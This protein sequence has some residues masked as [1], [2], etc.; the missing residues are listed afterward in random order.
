LWHSLLGLLLVTTGAVATPVYD[1]GLV[2]DPHSL[3]DP[4][5]VPLAVTHPPPREPTEAEVEQYRKEAEEAAENKNWL[6]RGFEQQQQL[7]NTGS[8]D[9]ST[10]L[11]LQLSSNKALAKLAGLPETDTTGTALKTGA[12]PGANGPALRNDTTPTAA[13][14]MP[15]LSDLSKPLVSPLSLPAGVTTFS[16]PPPLATTAPFGGI[17]PQSTPSSTPA[18]QAEES[19]DLD[20]PG[21][22]A[23][24]KDPSEDMSSA[25]LTL[26]ILPGESVEEARARQ[27]NFKAELALP[28]DADQLHK[29]Q[30][31]EITVPAV[32]KIA[33][34]D[35]T[36]QSTTPPKTK[37]EDDPSAPIPISQVPQINPVRAPIP[38]PFDILNR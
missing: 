36:A 26:D 1:S 35:K 14:G 30:T 9:Q 20:T 6:L 3:L 37:P 29:Q 24:K 33:T 13:T 12:A 34:D 4:D 28:M 25:D 22:T 5:G 17:L 10:D 18:R 16:A 8:P 31:S 38:G 15:Y 2:D 21:M 7:H 32:A 19:A 11:Y 27:D 23:A